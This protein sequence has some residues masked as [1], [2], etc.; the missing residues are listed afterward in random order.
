[1]VG[2]GQ[3]TISVSQV[4]DLLSKKAESKNGIPIRLSSKHLFFFSVSLYRQQLTASLME[5]TNV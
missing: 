4:P 2:G 5:I 3:F 1:M